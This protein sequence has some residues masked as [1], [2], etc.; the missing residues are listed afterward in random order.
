MSVDYGK[1]LSVILETCPY[2]MAEIARRT[3]LGYGTVLAHHA[4]ME[5]KDWGR[6]FVG[7]VPPSIKGRVTKLANRCVDEYG[8][9]KELPYRTRTLIPEELKSK[10]LDLDLTLPPIP[11]KP[12]PIYVPDKRWEFE[13]V[14]YGK[15]GGPDRR[16]YSEEFSATIRFQ[17]PGDIDRLEASAIGKELL[18]EALDSVNYPSVNSILS[19]WHTVGIA[20]G[21]VQLDRTAGDLK[22]PV[23]TIKQTSSAIPKRTGQ[24]M[25]G[26]KTISNVT[27]L[28]ERLIV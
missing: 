23:F 1:K 12:I 8:L 16:K 13:V 27:S 6:R 11:V 3:G 2:S 21:I 20:T 25:H 15:Q 7:K 26:P 22:D 18:D 9:D 14:W 24:I 10:I 28:L 19:S 17:T 4:W 5:G